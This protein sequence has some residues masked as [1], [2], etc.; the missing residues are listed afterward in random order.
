LHTLNAAG[1]VLSLDVWNVNSNVQIVAFGY[2][3]ILKCRSIVREYDSL[4]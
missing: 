4:V 1:L 2:E 3:S